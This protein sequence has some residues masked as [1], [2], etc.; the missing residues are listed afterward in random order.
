MAFNGGI[1]FHDATWQS[2]FGGSR[3]KSHGSHGCINMPK[4]KAKEMYDLIS[5]G[6]PVICHY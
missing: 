4:Q 6:T 2:S 5:D 3:Y 1:G